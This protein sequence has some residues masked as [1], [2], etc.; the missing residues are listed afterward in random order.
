MTQRQ[1]FK[2][3][4]KYDGFE[5]REYLPCVLAVVKTGA[6][7]A[8]QSNQGFGH[9]FSYIS[10]GNASG[11]KIA[12]TAPVIAASKEGM[13]APQWEMSFVMPA[14]SVLSEMPVPNSPNVIMRE[15]PSEDCA[16]VS[17]KG[18]ATDEVCAKKEKE[19]RAL[20]LA[21]GL[22]ASEEVRIARFDPP[23][24]PGFLHYNE[25]IIPLK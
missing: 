7:L 19:L 12:M 25:I 14:Q 3:I 11:Q 9:L 10:K 6:P 5:V 4:K 8:G 22:H 21:S 2:V 1:E 13:Q 20:I 17:F 16:V 18:R 15:M 24:K 23:F